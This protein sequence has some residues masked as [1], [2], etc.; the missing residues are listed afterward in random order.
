MIAV[1]TTFS[2]FGFDIYAKNM[3]LSAIDHLECDI[4]AYYENKYLDDDRINNI[5]ISDNV[6]EIGEFKKRHWNNMVVKGTQ[7]SHKTP[8]KKKD[9][10]NGYSFRYDAWKFC[11]KPLVMNDAINRIN[12]DIIYWIDADVVVKRCVPNLFF[13]NLLD[14]CDIT[15]LGRN[16]YH[17]ECGFVGYSVNDKTIRFCDELGKMYSEDKFLD[18]RE[19]HDSYLFDVVR[20]KMNLKE[21]NLTGT[22]KK[23]NV[24]DECVVGD[25]FSHLKGNMKYENSSI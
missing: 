25:Y 7:Q 19:W 10:Q 23:S 20:H 9:L 3:L 14:D 17:S 8:W 1:V 11:N 21:N 18:E 13:T 6:R 4:Y 15:F 2:D 22:L 5:K 24:F 12:A 16:N